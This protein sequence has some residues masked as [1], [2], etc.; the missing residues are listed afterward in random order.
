[1][2]TPWSGVRK[3][4]ST[5]TMSTWPSPPRS[6][7]VA[8]RPK[9][10]IQEALLQEVLLRKT[11]DTLLVTHQGAPPIAQESKRQGLVTIAAIRGTSSPIVTLREGKT[12]VEGLFAK[13]YTKYT[14]KSGENKSS[15][16]KKPRAF[17]ICEEYSSDDGDDDDD[18]KKSTKEDEGLLPSPFPP[19]QLPSSTLQMSVRD[20]PVRQ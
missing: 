15:P 19:P 4:S 17:L 14:S 7:G 2:T 1:M 13:G 3:I 9:A 20:M 12:M 11:Q 8:T 16:T 10:T 6:F 5:A 18:E